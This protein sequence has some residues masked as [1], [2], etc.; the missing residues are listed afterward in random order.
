MHSCGF[1]DDMISKPV[2]NSENSNNKFQETSHKIHNLTSEIK[3]HYG[4]Y[5]SFT[6]LILLMDVKDK[7]TKNISFLNSLYC[8]Y[9]TQV[10]KLAFKPF[11]FL[12]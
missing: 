5:S 2:E 10:F 3:N 1:A 9:L 12:I 8:V 6:D 11:L 4:T 7:F